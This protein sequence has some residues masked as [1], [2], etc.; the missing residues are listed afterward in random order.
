M[1]FLNYFDPDLENN[2]IL[3]YIFKGVRFIYSNYL[4]DM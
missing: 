4:Y 2:P 3:T 1:F